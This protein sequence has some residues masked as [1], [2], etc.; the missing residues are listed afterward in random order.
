MEFTKILFQ[1][2]KDLKQKAII[3]ANERQNK[4]LPNGTLKS[5]LNEA[6]AIGLETL[7]KKEKTLLA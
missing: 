1:V 3:I 6:L 2:R 5:V 4:E 7:K